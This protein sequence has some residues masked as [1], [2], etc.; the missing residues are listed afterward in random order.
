MFNRAFSRSAAGLSKPFPVFSAVFES[1]VCQFQQAKPPVFVNESIGFVQRFHWFCSTIPMDSFNNSIGFVS[2][3]RR[4]C[5]FHPA[6][7][8]F[9]SG[10][11]GHKGRHFRAWGT[12]K[13]GIKRA[14]LMTS[15]RQQKRIW[16]IIRGLLKSEN[17]GVFHL[18][19]SSV[20]GFLILRVK[21]CGR[22]VKRI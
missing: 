9:V 14:V 15:E 13:N 4:F 2:W 19:T 1:S 5:C 3:K 16:L 22:I 20:A 10:S 12:S 21:K 11:L 17:V 8:P 18:S 7:P 6:F